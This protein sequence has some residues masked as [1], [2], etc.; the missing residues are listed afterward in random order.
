MAV[1][2]IRIG[3]LGAAKIAPM[4]LLSPAR[5]LPGV[6]VSAVAARDHS[7]AAAFAKKHSIG[8]ALASYE[9]L[10][11]DPDLDAIYNPLPNA[12]HAEWTEKAIRAGKHV[13]CEKPF[14]SNAAEARWIADLADTSGLVV[15]E[16]FHYRYHPLFARMRE[17]VESG[18]LGKISRFETWM[19]IPL[20][21]PGN[22]RYSYELGGGAT[23]DT[24]CYAIHMLR[25]LAGEEPRVTSAA[26]KLIKANVDRW[27]TAEFAFPSGASGRMTC[28]LL[29]TSLLSI[30]AKVTGERGEMNVF[31]PILPKIYHNLKL[32][33][34]G[35][36]AVETHGR[37]DTYTHQLRTFAQ[38]IS[39]VR[40]GAAPPTLLTGP[41]DALANMRVIDAVYEKAG[42]DLRGASDD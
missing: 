25:H 18:E 4:A 36:I 32:N 38:A 23:M 28:S 1:N 10:I 41:R 27:M 17:V 16:A 14:T 34:D 11:A 15:M 22:I 12:L 40:G 8:R 42:L 19:C 20:P 39:E 33:I 6:E 3:V 2:P 26:S 37:D 29:S 35:K 7:K 9:E 13:L 24:G 5:S 31:N 21:L 30:G